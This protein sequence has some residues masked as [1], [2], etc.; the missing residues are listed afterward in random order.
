MDEKPSYRLL[1]KNGFE[2]FKMTKKAKTGK[3]DLG[4]KNRTFDK[5]NRFDLF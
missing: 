4:G 2:T 5:V 1:R 3:S